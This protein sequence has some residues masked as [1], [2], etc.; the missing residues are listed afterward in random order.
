MF[1]K[2]DMHV[3]CY[4]TVGLISVNL[5]VFLLFEI[6]GSNLD[7]KFMLMHGAMYTPYLPDSREWYRL[8]TSLFLHFGIRH[9]LNNMLILYVLGNYLERYLGRIRFLILYFAA[10]IGANIVSGLLA[11]YHGKVFVSAGAS[12]AI[13]GVLGGLTWVVLI[14]RGR[15]EDLTIKKMLILAVLSLYLGFVSSGV[16]NIAHVSGLLLG[17]LAAIFLYRRNRSGKRNE[18]TGG[19]V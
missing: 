13:F 6:F 8:F 18:Y 14:N 15:L 3:T 10:G 2:E 19:A 16:D 1:E 17:F 4:A 12:G 9:L 5:V 11:L 7:T